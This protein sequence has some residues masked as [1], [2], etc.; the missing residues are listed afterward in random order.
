PLTHED[1]MLSCGPLFHIFGT[2]THFSMVAV[3]GSVVFMEKLPASNKDI[4]YA[5][6]SNNVTAFGAPPLILEQMIPFLKATNDFS[7][8]RRLKFAIYGGAALKQES[9][10]WLRKEGINVVTLY[11]TTEI[12][13]IMTSDLSPQNSAWNSL[14]TYLKDPQG[15]DY[16][17]FETN[18]P[19]EPDVKHLYF[20]GDSPSLATN[21]GNR[22]DGGYDTNDLFKEDPNNP[23]YYI[24]LCRRD[25][26]L[27]LENGEKTNPLPME[28]VIRESNLVKQ[29][30]IFGQGRQCTA[31]L[32]ELDT[33]H[34]LNYSP[35]E[36]IAGVHEAIKRA[37]VE[38]PSHSRVLPQ[39]VKILPF[40]KSLPSTDKCTVKRKVA[41]DMFKDEIEKLYRNF[42]EGPSRNADKSNSDTSTWT[43]EQ[44]E[45][46]LLTSAAEVLDLDKS[47]LNDCSQ[48]LFDLGLNS[49]TSIQLRNKIAERFDNV[50][51]NFLFQNP[52][53]SLMREAL[54]NDKEQDMSEQTEKR[55]Q[56]TQDLTMTYIKR[57]K[58]DF[59]VAR[60]EYDEKKEKVILLT[61]ATGSLGSFMLRDLL[62]DTSVKKV[63]C[64]IRGKKE[65]LRQR[66]LDAFK[67]RSLDISLLDT[68]RVEV[69]P[70]KFSEPFLGFG[71]EIYDQLRN[72]VTIVQHC[73]WLLDFNM[74]V[75]HYVKECIEP[76][77][78]LLKFAYHQVNPMHVH[79]I[80]SVSASA[81][82]GDEVA[83]EPLPLDAHVCMPMGYA[84]SKFIV[85]KLFDY[86]TTEKNFPC[87]IERV[88]QVCGDSVNGVWN[89]T[90]QYPMMFVGGGS[91]MKKMPKLDNVVDWISV[92]YA[93]ATIVDIMLRTAHACTQ[94]NQYIYHIVNP[95]LISWNDVLQAMKASGMKF[96]IVEPVEWIQTLSKDQSNPCYRLM[97]FYEANFTSF[98]KMPVWKTEKTSALAP[99][100][101]DSPVFDANLFSKYLSHWQSVGF[102]NPLA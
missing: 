98:F 83:E 26:T 37:N 2:L 34:A 48:S 45:E 99:T 1:V 68:D 69:L 23:G 47:Q 40:S 89:I 6:K 30:A 90:E 80:S 9:G 12:G 59:S 79:F 7:S 41:H 50:P 14:R 95:H 96:D 18:D 39:M 54:L 17:V 82:V 75:D 88:G 44:T 28:A 84:Q 10:D 31:A 19:S 101:N 81:A 85:E 87:Y 13:V 97:S 38:C 64:C 25:D 61:G 21:V 73:A 92:D 15:N 72:E 22:P 93:A 5:L 94:E 33:E 91:I 62:K 86:L 24:Y 32:I 49:L 16:G 27:V 102:Y 65:Q 11:G 3:G 78:N 52:S 20:R 76:F 51:Q 66:L 8:M 63:Y 42:L 4:D 74:P 43:L 70:M 55:Y 36:I 29:V 35:D 71:Q 58:A 60:N 56:Q 57:A 100:I 77:Y 53:I 46:F 67:S